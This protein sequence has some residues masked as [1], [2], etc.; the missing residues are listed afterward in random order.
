MRFRCISEKNDEKKSSMIYI[1]NVICDGKRINDCSE[2]MSKESLLSLPGVDWY[3]DGTIRPGGLALGFMQEDTEDIEYPIIVFDDINDSLKLYYK[4]LLGRTL[5]VKDGFIKNLNII[6]DEL[7]EHEIIIKAETID[8]EDTQEKF[9]TIVPIKTSENYLKFK[10]A[11]SEHNFA[12]FMFKSDYDNGNYKEDNKCSNIIIL[13]KESKIKYSNWIIPESIYLGGYESEKKVLVNSDTLEV[14]IYKFFDISKVKLKNLKMIINEIISNLIAKKLKLPVVDTEFHMNE[15]NIG[16]ISNLVTPPVHKY[17]QIKNKDKIMT[18]SLIDMV[19]FDVFVCNTDR[20]IDN[21]CFSKSDS[22]YQ[23][24]LIDHMR[25]L[26]GYENTDKSQLFKLTMAYVFNFTGLSFISDEI[27]DIRQFQGIIAK[28]EGLNIK[29]LFK[30]FSYDE[31][32][33][34]SRV[35]DISIDEYIK[36]MISGL[37]YRQRNIKKLIKSTLGL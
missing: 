22:K 34:F 35:F 5:I 23:P 26:G 16:V 10:K 28:I 20:H 33:V 24:Y 31:L 7:R 30:H 13:K 32:Q 2:F 29:E 17:N 37:E 19:A 1:N 14:G 11:Y 12:Y 18:L 15:K 25:C 8:L 36:R 6:I 4:E 3:K 27:N 9:E 21:I